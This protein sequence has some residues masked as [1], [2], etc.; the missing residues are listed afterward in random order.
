[1]KP[2]D[3]TIEN[4]WGRWPLRPVSMRGCEWLE[5]Q[6]EANGGGGD[7][8]LISEPGE[9]MTAVLT[10]LGVGLMIIAFLLWPGSRDSR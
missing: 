2:A 1:M 5:A 7:G 4:H 8:Q 3:V 9:K 10:L 6:A